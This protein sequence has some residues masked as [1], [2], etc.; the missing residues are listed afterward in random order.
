MFGLRNQYSI[1]FPSAGQRRLSA[2]KVGRRL[3]GPVVSG[4]R[5]TSVLLSGR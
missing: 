3:F 1:V 4:G 5:G 2:E